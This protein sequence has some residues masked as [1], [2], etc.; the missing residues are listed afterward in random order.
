[1]IKTIEVKKEM[2]FR[3]LLEYII[4]N[5]VSGRFNNDKGYG[6][7]VNAN[8]NHFAF[9]KNFAYGRG[10]TYE[11]EFEQE[12]TEDTEF[13]CLVINTEDF[14]YSI[15]DTSIKQSRDK[16]PE[17][18]EIFARIDGRLQKIWECE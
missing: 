15:R 16:L 7:S 10:E 3:E 12:I 4:Q 6:F 11:L 13:E 17:V 8:S 9:D 18:I 1:M 14:A 2:T 5:D